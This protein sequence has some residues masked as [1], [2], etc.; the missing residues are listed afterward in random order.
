M[1]GGRKEGH[2][3]KENVSVRKLKK[4]GRKMKVENPFS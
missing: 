3:V 2:V 4:N 1:R